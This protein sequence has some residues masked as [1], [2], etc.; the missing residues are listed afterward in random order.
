VTHIFAYGSLMIRDVMRAVTGRDFLSLPA[1]LRDHA[2]YSVRGESYPGMIPAKGIRTEGILYLDLDSAA[3]NRLDDFE[4][5]WYERLP[6]R[7]YTR[8]G[9]TLEAET[10][11]FKSEYR[12]LLTKDA[13][14][15]ELFTRNHLRTF[16]ANYKGFRDLS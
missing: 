1:Y 2:R 10:Y 4:G 15:L 5:E 7:V 8:E 11:L 12:G 16:M 14:D 6:V 9:S 3:V 13:W